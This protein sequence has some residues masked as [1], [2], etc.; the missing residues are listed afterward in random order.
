MALRFETVAEEYTSID[1]HPVG[2]ATGRSDVG[3]S[4]LGLVAID[5]RCDYP[6]TFCRQQ[7]GYGRSDTPAAASD[8]GA[9]MIV[10]Y[11]K[12]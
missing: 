10:I 6:A 11:T 12:A 3:S 8:D 7:P 9:L 1:L 4:G 2:A 5:I